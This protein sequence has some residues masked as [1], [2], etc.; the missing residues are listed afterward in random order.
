MSL[1][2]RQLEVA[3]GDS[4]QA[5]TM[6]VHLGKTILGQSETHRHELSGASGG[7][8]RYSHIRRTIVDP[9]KPEGEQETDV[10]SY[11]DEAKTS[12]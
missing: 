1:R 2:S 10:T 8:I 6:L 11:C 4:P 9:Q 12:R 3:Y 7:P 5:V